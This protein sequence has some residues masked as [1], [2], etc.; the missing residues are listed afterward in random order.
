MF[1]DDAGQGGA[2]PGGPGNSAGSNR[3]TG[4][5]LVQLI[6][7]G[8]ERVSHP[9]FDPWVQ[10]IGDDVLTSLYED[11]V[12]IRRIDAEATALQ[13]QGELALW[14]PL[15]GQ[16]AS[17]IGSARALREDDFVF[18][19]YRDNGVAYVR[20]VKPADIVKAWRGNALAGWDP[21]TVNVAT[22]QIIIGAQSL[23][24]TGYAMGIQNDGADSAAVA[25]FGDGATSEG[26]VNEAMVFAASFQAPVIFFC[27]NNHWAI[28]EPVMLQSHIQIADRASGFG[29]PSMRVDGNDVLA[30]LAATRIALDR[31]RRG[32]G[33][34]FIEAVTYR[35]GPHTTADDPTRY[36]DANELEDWA[37]KDPIHRLKAL[38]ERK[39]LLTAD[40]EA[41]VAATAD[42][43]AK[44]LRSGT[45]TMPEPQPLQIFEHV[46]STPHSWLDRQQDHYTRYL[47]SFGDPAGAPSEE[48]AR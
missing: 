48:G 45:I 35:M 8:G 43:V 16:E 15:L 4:G 28:S 3:R 5:D 10:D 9:E 12:A 31:A 32:G 36:R 34:T 39:G 37:A 46:Y 40:V 25:Y 7:P 33:P 42:A 2:A 26:D 27:Q 47:A 38:L 29:I 21:Y 14:P 1:T 30:V 41:A 23:H 6:T 22:Q 13:R 20:G 24:A 11:M 18:P 17:Q 19:S 44:E